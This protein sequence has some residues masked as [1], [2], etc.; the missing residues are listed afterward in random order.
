MDARSAIPQA[1]RLP[2]A[3]W[4]KVQPYLPPKPKSPRGGRPRNDDRTMLEAIFYVLRTG[5]QWKAL[6][7]EIAAGSSVHDRFQEW[8]QAGVFERLW[9]LGILTF[10]EEVGLEWQWQSMDG[11]MTKAPLGGE[12]SGPNP[13]DRGK[14]GTKRC[15]LTEGHGIP[16]AVTV[17]GANRHDMKMTEATLESLVVQ[18][19]EP[20]AEAPHHLCLDKGFDFLEVQA[21]VEAHHYVAHIRHRGEETQAKR[22]IP[23]YRARRWVVE[24]THSWMNR[25]RRLLI[26]WEKKRENYLAM[27]QLACAYICF[28]AAKVF[29]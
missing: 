19:P 9:Q 26:R 27:L 10:D 12:A 8:L 25:F 18:R 17:D 15:V 2:Q 23:G 20:S 22:V 28:R 11:A 6:P 5:M 29:G 3:M 16:L 7:R 24:R 1:F 4:E 13:T 21:A 14:R